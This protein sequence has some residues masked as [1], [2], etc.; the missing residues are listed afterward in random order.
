MKVALLLAYDGTGFSGFARQRPTVRTVQ[1]ELEERLTTILRAP[2]GITGAGRTDAGVHAAGQVVSF[3]APDGTDPAWVRARLNRWLGPEIAIR[4]AAEAPDGFD[5]RF[6][7]MRREY[8]YRVYQSDAPDPFRD[9]FEVWE[10]ARLTLTTMRAAGRAFVGEHDFSSF[11]RRGDG[12][13]V[14]RVR[15]VGV[16]RTGDDLRFEVVADAF[17]HQQ[18]RSMVGMLL[19]VGRGKRAP[20]DVVAAL[21]AR[22][23][24]AAGP[25]APARGLH[26][27]RVVYRPD[28]FASATG[29]RTR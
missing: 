13:L 16:T 25:V 15:R 12:S 21:G 20:Q 29:R 11:C 7:A 1:G 18:V 24:A 19:E 26:L 27:M 4:A 28:P 6:S 14:R 9:R 10:P 8:D 22:D 17:C 2:I 3:D 23:R 5:A